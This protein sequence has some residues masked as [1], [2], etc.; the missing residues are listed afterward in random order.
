M[1]AALAMTAG[2]AITVA[3]AMTAALAV[4]KN[5]RRTWMAKHT[6]LAA[7]AQ[8]LALKAE[9]ANRREDRDDS[10]GTQT[11]VPARQAAGLSQQHNPSHASVR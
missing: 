6:G 2:L 11:P 3:L 7:R 4:K 10:D 8:A 5:W 9:I 1:T